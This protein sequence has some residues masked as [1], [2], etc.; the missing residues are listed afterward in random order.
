MLGGLPTPRVPCELLDGRVLG[1]DG[2]DYTAQ[3]EK[4]AA[5]VL[6]MALLYGCRAAI[7]KA[8]SPSCGVG[9]VYDGS[10]SGTLTAGSG[11]TA[12]L[13]SRNGI[14]VLDENS[15]GDL[16]PAEPHVAR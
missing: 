11:V 5:E 16:L 3:Y 6:K 2:A 1:K 8:R 7:L 9:A 10:F 14:R 12:A 15:A 13:L 4:G